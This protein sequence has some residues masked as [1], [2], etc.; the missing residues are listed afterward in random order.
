MNLLPIPVH[1]EEDSLATVLSLKDVA[2]IKGFY[3]TMDNRAEQSILVYLGDVKVLKFLECNLGLYFCD[4][5]N[6]NNKSVVSCSSVQTVT[7]KEILLQNP[8]Y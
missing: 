6:K 7:E 1:F 4:N 2:N 8:K 3:V 5:R